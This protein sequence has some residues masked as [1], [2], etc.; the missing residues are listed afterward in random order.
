M[1]YIPINPPATTWVKIGQN[2]SKFWNTSPG[3]SSALKSQTL[4]N[5]SCSKYTYR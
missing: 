1:L 5:L 4:S 2:Q 3:L